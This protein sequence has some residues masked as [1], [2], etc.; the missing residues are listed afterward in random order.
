MTNAFKNRIYWRLWLDIA[1]QAWLSLGDRRFRT[2]LSV[3]GI[4]FGI[5]T[6]TV[7]SV[8]THGGR[9][10][11]FSELQSFGLQTVWIWR[12]RM[13]V[14]PH[15]EQRAG[16]G[17]NNADF[18]ALRNSSCCEAIMRMS[19][20]IYMFYM[21][22]AGNVARVGR[23]YSKV[24]IE[25]VNEDYLGINNDHII[26]GRAFTDT[27]ISRARP[28]ALI[29]FQLRNELFKNEISPIGHEVHLDNRRYEVIGVLAHKDRSLLASLSG[30]DGDNG[31]QVLI[32][33]TRAQAVLNTSQIYALQGQV[34][35]GISAVATAQSMA[36]YLKLRQRNAYSYQIQA[37]EQHAQTANNILSGVSI[38]GTV[39]ASV[40][41]FVAG[42]GILN[43]MS[44]AVLERT[45]E[46][47]V[48]KALGGNEREILLQF[49]FEAA[50]ISLFGGIAGLLLGGVASVGIALIAKIPFELSLLLNGFSL[51]VAIGVGLAS[52]FYPAFRAARLKPVEALRY[53]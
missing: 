47:G 12:D 51:L 53:E 49:L 1:M 16:T 19:P 9:E 21:S 5:A 26:E 18:E 48:R 14:D 24:R 43:I 36:D 33:Y 22:D 3:C 46:I 29:S 45:R 2:L 38:I 15:K 52:G 35:E 11:V 32:P 31:K 8:V 37:M 42:L 44:T 6:V 13:I 17:I 28:V 41:L 25:G 30:M 50:F 40:S 20:V 7:I 27:D 4:A 10:K 39:A 23:L 34:R